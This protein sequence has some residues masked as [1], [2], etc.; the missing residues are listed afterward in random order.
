M[1]REEKKLFVHVAV[2]RRR[3]KIHL[4]TSTFFNFKLDFLHFVC[5]A[6]GHVLFFFYVSRHFF[7]TKPTRTRGIKTKCPKEKKNALVQCPRP[8]DQQM[9]H[10]LIVLRAV[11]SFVYFLPSNDRVIQLPVATKVRLFLVL[12]LSSRAKNVLESVQ[13]KPFINIANAFV[14]PRSLIRWEARTRFRVQTKHLSWCFCQ[15]KTSLLSAESSFD[16]FNRK[17]LGF[18]F[19]VTRQCNSLAEGFHL[20]HA[21]GR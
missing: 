15:S 19:S 4:C 13:L 2:Q 14:L 12:D 5:S 8:P 21:R 6:L 20:F 1:N 18:W 7:F 16:D 11:V 17:D 3:C 10:Q 9:T